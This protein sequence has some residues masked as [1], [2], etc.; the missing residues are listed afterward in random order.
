MNKNEKV[1]E[2]SK[3]DRHD[4]FRDFREEWEACCSKWSVNASIE[5]W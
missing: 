1:L 5:K 2:I 3:M 4:N